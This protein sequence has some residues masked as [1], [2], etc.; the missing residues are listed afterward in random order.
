MKKSLLLLVVISF[1]SAIPASAFDWIKLFN[2]YQKQTTQTKQYTNTVTTADLLNSLAQIQNQTATVDKSVQNSFL[3]IVSQMSGQ[4]T[5]NQLQS[6]IANIMSAANKSEIEK[7]T[8]INQLM[9]GYATNYLRTNQKN[10]ASTVQNMTY[11]QRAQLLADVATMA[12][13]GQEY[14][15]LAKQGLSV[16]STALKVAKTGADVVQ[17]I[18]KINQTAAALKS[19]ASAVINVVNQVKTISKYAGYFI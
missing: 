4:N 12:Q 18:S 16:A 6:N 1:V 9:T 13:G 14:A 17:T 7:D 8:L 3:S 5:S 19:R 15:A 10:L 2:P 11:T